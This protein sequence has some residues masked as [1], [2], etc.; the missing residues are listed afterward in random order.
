M[1]QPLRLI[2]LSEETSPTPGAGYEEDSAKQ[3]EVAATVKLLVKRNMEVREML[4]MLEAIHPLIMTIE[5]I[6]RL[7]IQVDGSF[8]QNPS[9]KTLPAP[10]LGAMDFT[11]LTSPDVHITFAKCTADNVQ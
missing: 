2:S 9:P 5:I 6:T 4:T 7:E 1:R 3:R 10:N 11:T 8:G